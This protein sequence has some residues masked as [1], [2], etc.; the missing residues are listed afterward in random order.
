MTA[1]LPGMPSLSS[2]FRVMVL[3]FVGTIVFLLLVGFY[4]LHAGM[5]P[6]NADARPPQFERWAAHTALRA[7]LARDMRSLHG[8]AQTPDSVLIKG[9]HLYKANCLVCHGASDGKQSSVAAGLYQHPPQFGKH[10]VADDPIEMTYWKIT[11]GIRLTGMPSYTK[12]LTDDERWAIA[13]FLRHE[14]SLPPG[15]LA[16]WKSLPS[17]ATP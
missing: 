1:I 12:T 9:V 3:T 5:V 11:H 15:A 8:P 4:C 7:V 17:A 13:A 10:D 16:E 14:D 2:P 6:A